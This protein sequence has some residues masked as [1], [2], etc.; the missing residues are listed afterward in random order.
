MSTLSIALAIIADHRRG[1]RP[2]NDCFAEAQ[3]DHDMDDDAMEAILAE[4]IDTFRAA[5]W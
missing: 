4:H 3:M 1:G 2:W 5:G